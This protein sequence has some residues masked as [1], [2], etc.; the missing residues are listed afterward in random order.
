MLQGLFRDGRHK[1]LRF[2]SLRR[3]THMQSYTHYRTDTLNQPPTHL[4]YFFLI[5]VGPCSGFELGL[6]IDCPE[7]KHY[8]SPTFP[9]SLLDRHSSTP[10]SA[11]LVYHHPLFSFLFSV[12][13]LFCFADAH[14]QCDNDLPHTHSGPSFVDPP[15]PFFPLCHPI[16][17][18]P[19]EQPPLRAIWFMFCCM[20]MFSFFLCRPFFP[21]SPLY[22]F[23]T[24]P[25]PPFSLPSL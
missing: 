10:F 17:F 25:S 24:V 1:S 22:T 20:L 4:R 9:W 6:L 23:S 7:T 5:F 8:L 19:S 21:R 11:M 18:P 15:P 3:H 14:Y 13:L 12:A 2:R 16:D